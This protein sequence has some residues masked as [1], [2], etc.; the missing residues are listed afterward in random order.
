MYAGSCHVTSV[1]SSPMWN[2]VLAVQITLSPL[3]CEQLYF[4]W[5]TTSF[6]LRF[7]I[8]R[9]FLTISRERKASF[10]SLKKQQEDF[11]VPGHG[12]LHGEISI[13]VDQFECS[14]DSQEARWIF[15][16]CWCDW[17]ATTHPLYR[18]CSASRTSTKYLLQISGD[19][20]AGV[21][22]IM[23]WSDIGGIDINTGDQSLIYGID[24]NA[25][26]AMPTVQQP[27][28]R[29]LWNQSVIIEMTSSRSGL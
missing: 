7:I 22:Q 16:G 5:N 26:Q 20:K 29:Y 17:K 9:M 27:A 1:K 18:R 11:F 10:E 19:K 28:Q 6:W 12:E 15:S 24:P 21:N 2:A 23:M 8:Y 25:Q 14:G 4:V 13:F 3:Q